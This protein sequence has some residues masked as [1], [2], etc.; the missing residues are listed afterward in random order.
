[1]LQNKAGVA[2]EDRHGRERFH[3]YGTMTADG[4]RA[5]LRCGLDADDPR[6]QAA[7][8]WLERN[9]SATDNPGQWEDD[10]AVLQNATYYYWTWSVSHALMGLDLQQVKTDQGQV[11]WA[12]VLADEVLGR[13][14]RD[15]AWVNRDIDGREDCPLV[16]TPWAAATLAVCRYVLTSE[17]LTLAHAGEFTGTVPT[18]PARPE[19][20]R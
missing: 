1:L 14:K 3:S 5:L 15:G 11:R 19:T 16:A 8:R 7:R 12:E 18:P 17:Q 20:D 9:F 10:R 13:Q 4:L 2:G 6:V